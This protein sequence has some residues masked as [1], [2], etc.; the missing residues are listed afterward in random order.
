M[1]TKTDEIFIEAGKMWDLKRLYT[2]L[3]KIK[4]EGLSPVERLYLRGLLCGHSPA[5]MA[6]KLHKSLNGIEANLC[7]T[8]YHYTKELLQKKAVDNWRNISEWLE[9]S[10]YRITITAISEQVEGVTL[11]VENLETL[12]KIVHQYNHSTFQNSP[13]FQIHFHSIATMSTET[14]K[15]MIAEAEAK[16]K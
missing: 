13:T 12:V 14:L 6:D 16:E 4:G 2:D 11:P 5:D 8:V 3:A 9:Q 1:A 10:G 7:K 15:Q